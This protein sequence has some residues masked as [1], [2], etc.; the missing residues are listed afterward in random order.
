VLT[1]SLLAHPGG[2]VDE[3]VQHADRPVLVVPV[4]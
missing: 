2:T 3:L 4:R 1:R